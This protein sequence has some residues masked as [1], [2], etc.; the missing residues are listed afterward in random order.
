MKNLYLLLIFFTLLKIHPA[1]AEDVTIGYVYSG[2]HNTDF[3]NI[4]VSLKLEK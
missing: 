3:S 1:G 4:S 2:D